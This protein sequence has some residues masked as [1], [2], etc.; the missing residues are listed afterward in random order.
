MEGGGK[1]G[2]L[3]PRYDPVE[4]PAKA[5]ATCERLT[6]KLSGRGQGGRG[7]WR[8]TSKRGRWATVAVGIF[9]GLLILGTILPSQK[10]TSAANARAT[11]ATTPPVVQTTTTVRATTT[12]TTVRPEP[13]KSTTTPPPTTAADRA[14]TTPS[15]IQSTTAAEPAAPSGRFSGACRSGDPLANVYHPYRLHIVKSC[16]T[17]TG[18]IAYVSRE[19]D[20]DIHVNLSLPPSESNLLDAANIADEYGNLVTEI[21][22]ADQPGCTPGQPPPLPPT[23][24]RSYSYSYGICTGA[25]VV[26]PVVGAQVAVTGPYVLDTDHGWMEIHPVWSMAVIGQT[27]SP[28][29]STAHSAPPATSATPSASAYCEANAAPAN[30]G[31]SGDYEVYVRSNQPHQKATAS[32]A[33]DAW[34]GETDASGSA[35]ILLYHTSPGMTITVTVGDSSCSTTA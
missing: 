13:T 16:I 6:M 19:N 17:V 14:T 2:A 5:V 10:K 11:T 27:S 18:T 22:P 23:A 25:D 8:Q 28:P 33:G 21:V 35:S 3:P 31:Y 32:D 26:T 12:F 15:G 24:Y 9:V 34:S 1:L 30:D 29:T 20:G 7:W 4:R